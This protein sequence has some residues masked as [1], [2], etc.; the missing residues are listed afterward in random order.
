[1][2][3]LLTFLLSILTSM[4]V[5]RTLTVALTMTGLTR[6]V[7]SFQAL[8]AFSG[9]GF[10][11]SEAEAVIDHPTRRR[12]IATGIRIGSA[13]VVAVL[14]S[15]AGS[16]LQ[17]IGDDQLLVRGVLG[18]LGLIG[19]VALSTSRTIDRFISPI[20]RRSLASVTSLEDRDYTRLLRLSCGFEVAEVAVE[21]GSWLAHKTLR[22]L[23]LHAE[24]LHVLGIEREGVGYLAIPT[25]DTVLQ[26]G[27]LLV[28]YGP[29]EGTREIGDRAH[30]AHHARTAAVR[31]ED[32]RAARQREEERPSAADRPS[33]T[34]R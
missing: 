33:M 8:S 21:E 10:T 16:V 18:L 17:A 7:A 1:M 6:E 20:L 3:L 11:T 22:E 26:P 25:P 13:G 2:L 4:L 32:A 12:I 31:R 34:E 9:A 30:H 24:G 23:D 14:A 19:L 27:D 28:I 29:R 15:G 5:V